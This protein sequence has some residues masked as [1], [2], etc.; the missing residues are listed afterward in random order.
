[1]GA[2]C[3]GSPRTSTS[4]RS[5]RARLAGL[6]DED[7]SILEAAAVQ[8]SAFGPDLLAH[9]VGRSRLEVLQGLARLERRGGIVR[10]GTLGFQFDHHQL[11]EVVY[12]AT[13]HLLR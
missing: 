13:P 2:R 5:P 7:R 4:R 12:E 1:M 6:G 8:G 9:T 3:C 10:S 11:Q